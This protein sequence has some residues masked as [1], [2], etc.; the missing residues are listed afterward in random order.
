[1]PDN[2]QQL[3]NP[4]TEAREKYAG[5]KDWSDDRILK[6][7]SDPVKFKSAF[8]QYKDLPDDVI[9]RNIGK[10]M[11][12]S[13]DF[14]SNP[15]KE[16]LYSMFG[17]IPG[18]DQAVGQISVPYS[19]VQKARDFGYTFYQGS[20][21][22]YQKDKAAEGQKPGFIGRV[23]EKVN[24]ALQ[25][26][27]NEGVVQ[28]TALSNTDRAALRVA[29]GLPGYLRDVFMA[30]KDFQSG[31][32]MQTL[33]DLIDPMKLPENLYKQFQSD[34]K[35]GDK[36]L[37]VQNLVGTLAGMA[38][39]AAL[40]HGAQ[41]AVRKV[42]LGTPEGVKEHVREFI[43]AKPVK[44]LVA[45][46]IAENK[47]NAETHLEVL[48][49][50]ID[51]TRQREDLHSA[52]EQKANDEA[53]AKL[54]EKNEAERQKVNEDN[55]KQIEKENK[56][57][58]AVAQKNRETAQKHGGKAVDYDPGEL[59]RVKEEN[60]RAIKLEKTR[61][62]LENDHRQASTRLANK[63]KAAFNK[64]RS[65]YN[66]AWNA[67]RDKVKGV[68]V[69]MA[70][71]VTEIKAREAS[72]DPQQ[73][74]QFRSILRETEPSD[75]TLS[76]IK[77]R[78]KISEQTFGRPY[79]N[80][81]DTE[82]K[83]IDEHVADI[84]IDLSDPG[85]ANVPATRLHGWKS[86]LERAVRTTKDGTIRYAIGKVLDSVRQLETE[87]SVKAGAG[88]E[89]QNARALTGPYF[90]AFFKSPDDL[91]PE[92]A[93]SLKQQTPEQ[94]KA[95]GEADR[96]NRIAAYDPSI[97]SLSHHIDNLAEALRNT[98]KPRS[99]Q[100][101]PARPVAQPLP[102][103]GPQKEFTPEPFKPVE[104][105][106]PSRVEHPDRP[107]TIRVGP[108]EAQ[109]VREQ[110]VNKAAEWLRNRSTWIATSA[111]IGRM[112]WENLHGRI[113]EGAEAVVMGMATYYT[114]GKIADFIEK[115]EVTRWLAEPPQRDLQE[116]MKLPEDQRKSVQ[117]A[118]RPGIEIAKAKGVKVAPA[119]L[120]FV[121]GIAA[122]RV[123]VKAPDGK[124]YYFPDEQSAQRFRQEAGVQ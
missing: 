62:K 117:E 27:P 60:E 57:R 16:G 89:L 43:P 61:Q 10:L 56:A 41:E 66:A 3:W 88:E 82:R 32:D 120:A 11:E 30:A 25:P 50:A 98:P 59:A 69:E 76:G 70:P 85:L 114:V 39:V 35:S 81:T 20:G 65:Q 38:G 22:Q 105:P 99:L 49:N 100:D 46:T 9:K 79:G 116:L 103:H 19:K 80:L 118:M 14:T 33:P 54:E 87:A 28:P 34:W 106:K 26:V 93:R 58:L 55:L 84:G 68:D 53:R 4:V 48:Q 7:L 5:L 110:A 44:E 75:E 119:L 67:W 23:S 45:K 92:A 101:L 47:K 37:A 21:E 83:A 91:P 63:Y 18:K 74:A 96:L 17:L 72:M 123:P 13:S 97:L 90:E 12:Q 8:P 102:K 104:L 112:M 73:V 51:R 94:V 24:K 29:A 52:K 6:N 124:V 113:S 115:P 42:K 95:Q 15:N 109:A 121:S 108:E 1:M 31:K 36:Q 78:E 64:A 111:I 122:T 2:N 71:V 40:T 86:Q 107:E 77:Q